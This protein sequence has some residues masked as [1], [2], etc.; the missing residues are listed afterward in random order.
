MQP[1]TRIVVAAVAAAVVSASLPAYAND[2][3]YDHLKCFK[4]RD[5]LTDRRTIYLADIFPESPFASQ[6]DC[7]LRL[8]AMHFCVN[9]AKENVQVNGEPFATLPVPGAE[10][11]RDYL[12]YDLKC[13][14]DRLEVDALDQFGA[15]PLRVR[16]SDFLCM[17][18]NKI[19]P[20]STPTPSATPTPTPT[21]TPPPPNPCRLIIDDGPQVTNGD[22]GSL[23][24]C[25]GDCPT[26]E[27]C[28]AEA[29]PNIDIDNCR[30][31]PDDQSCGERPIGTGA[32]FPMCGGLCPSPN[33]VCVQRFT[34]APEDGGNGGVCQCLL[35]G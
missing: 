7:R 25:G 13:D 20:G 17:P 18:A 28:L 4:I 30:C 1:L 33:Q 3:D 29:G 21:H 23:G 22:R 2:R 9:V 32:P 8:P 10:E 34:A 5:S 35:P 31:V 24:F 6:S 14:R 27:T 15:R 19:A 26:G 16:K 12:C 11:G